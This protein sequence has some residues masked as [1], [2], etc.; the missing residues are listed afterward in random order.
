MPR[1]ITAEDFMRLQMAGDPQ[2]SPDGEQIAFVRKSVDAE[3]RK[4]RSEI[5]L[6]PREAGEPHRFTGSDS[7][8]SHPRWSPDGK[9]L[10][11]LSDRQKPKS[12]I[13]VIPA[14]GGEPV[15]L[16]K[17]ETEGGISGFRWSPDGTKIAFL[18]RATPEAYRKEKVEERQKQEQPAPPRVHMTLNYRSDGS[19]FVDGEYPQ[20]WVADAATGECRQLTS[21]PFGV[22]LPVWSPDSKTL[23]FLSDRR[24][25]SDIAPY[26]DA[27]IWTVPTEGGEL[28]RL[29]APPGDKFGLV[30][31]PDGT[32]FAYLGNPDL[33]DTW[34][35]NNPRL[36]VLP[37]DGGETARD[38]TGS[39]DLYIGYASLSDAHEIGG[40][41][42]VQ[43]NADGSALFFPVSE[44]GDT[45]LM[46]I[47]ANGGGAM[48]LSPSGG[49]LGGFSL[50]PHGH[51]AVTFGTPTCPQDLFVLSAPRTVRGEV[52]SQQRTFFNREFLEEVTVIVPESVE[53][54]NGEGGAVHGWLLRPAEFDA[55]QT[56]PFVLYVHGGPHT[57]YGNIFL[58]ELQA[59]A[60]EGY[61]VLYVNPRGSVGYGEAHT[62]AIK[63]DWGNR[64]YQDI[65]AAADYAEGLPFVDQSKMAIMGGSYG[66]YMTAW[67]VGHTDRF[68]CAIADR[69]VGNLHSMA[70][71]TD[72]AWRHGAYFGG[73]TWN[74]PLP[75]W[76]LSPLA[77]AGHVTTPLLIIHSD[78]DLRCPVGQAEELFAA[79]RMQGKTVEFVRYPAETSHGMSR[80]GPPILRLDRLQ[81]NFGWLNRWLKPEK[82]AGKSP[83][84]S[85]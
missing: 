48:P 71:T 63:G 53:F 81:R 82:A 4:Y 35:T 38:L 51:A 21:G 55:P 59:L 17:I 23:A 42:I 1:K 27:G 52:E 58:H 3:K 76:K 30:W 56:Y 68:A 12:R 29:V 14:D 46:L 50:S 70:G 49:E 61:V 79:L 62:K 11:F 43:W 67:A 32:R 18:F 60:A 33:D 64:D 13:Y 31:S 54:P 47:M 5:W 41:D 26:Y 8:D 45:R 80:S 10:A 20:V 40:G 74:D 75:L 65:L 2:F 36:F 44:R 73:D 19:G 34:G 28:T 66:G 69:L 83:A 85:E 72:F 15:G 6:A 37:A 25:D 84:D 9:R 77:Y 16:T 24:P 39:A 7:N 78:G 57:Q 22:G